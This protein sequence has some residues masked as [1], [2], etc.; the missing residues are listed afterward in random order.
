MSTKLERRS[1]MMGELI[2][3]LHRRTLADRLT[4]TTGPDRSD[5]RTSLAGYVV[6]LRCQETPPL[7]EANGSIPAPQAN[8][9][10]VISSESTGEMV[11]KAV[12]SGVSPLAQQKDV[13]AELYDHA[14]EQ[15]TGVEKALTAILDELDAD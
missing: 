15:A 7:P 10:L 5:V 13:I 4:W 9:H 2:G 3:K 11:D 12:I 6:K 1:M 8:Y 14:Y